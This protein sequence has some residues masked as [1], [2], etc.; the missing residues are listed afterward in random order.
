[1]KNIT[2]EQQSRQTPADSGG[3]SA[4]N[5]SP[6][7]WNSREVHALIEDA[8]RNGRNPALLCLG[9]VE[10]EALERYLTAFTDESEDRI[11]LRGYHYAGLRI[12]VLNAES[13]LRV[14]TLE[15]IYEQSRHAEQMKIKMKQEGEKSRHLRRFDSIDDGFRLRV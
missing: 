15:S 6:T 7:S 4:T 9:R 5:Q 11:N 10:A 14:E 13:V 1:M 2:E 3:M 8:H 12:V